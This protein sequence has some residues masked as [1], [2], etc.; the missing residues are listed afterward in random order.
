MLFSIFQTKMKLERFLWFLTFDTL[1]TSESPKF[2]GSPNI[3]F[4][5]FST[6]KNQFCLLTDKKFI[7]SE[8]GKDCLCFVKSI[9]GD[10]R[11]LGGSDATKN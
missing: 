1:V 5:I 4:T 7:F 6:H 10:P 8:K 9:F 3:L 2:C 11:N